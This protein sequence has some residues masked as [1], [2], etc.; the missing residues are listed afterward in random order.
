L[1]TR[2]TK[3]LSAKHPDGEPTPGEASNASAGI[4]RI[5]SSYQQLLRIAT[6]PTIQHPHC[7]DIQGVFT[8]KHSLRNGVTAYSA[9]SPVSVTF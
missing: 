1:H 9:L 7:I 2:R 8:H 6:Q 5:F 3:R 4:A